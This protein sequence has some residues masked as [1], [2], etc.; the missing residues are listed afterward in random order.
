M[1]GGRVL[2]AQPTDPQPV[3]LRPTVTARRRGKA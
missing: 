2:P 3:D 1:S